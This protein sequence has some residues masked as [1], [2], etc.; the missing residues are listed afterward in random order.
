MVGVLMLFLAGDSTVLVVAGA[1]MALAGGL[2]AFHP[3]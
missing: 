1:V 2:L 3:R